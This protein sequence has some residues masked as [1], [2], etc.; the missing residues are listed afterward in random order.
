MSL[1]LVLGGFS[2]SGIDG[3]AHWLSL[4]RNLSKHHQKLHGEGYLL[5]KSGHTTGRMYRPLS[6][7]MITPDLPPFPVRCFPPN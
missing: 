5:N 4:L 2:Q 7:D 6:L 3:Y 1:Y